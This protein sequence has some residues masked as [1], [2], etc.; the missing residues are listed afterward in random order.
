MT[1]P[2]YAQPLHQQ[3]YQLI[4]ASQLVDAHDLLI[5]ALEQDQSNPETWQL[6]GLIAAVQHD[7]ETAITLL[8]Q[9][10]TL[11]G[12]NVLT[13]KLLGQLALEAG[14]PEAAVSWLT[15][16]RRAAPDD[17]EAR[18]A[19]ACAYAEAGETERAKRL[20]ASSEPGEPAANVDILF[21][22]ALFAEQQ[23]EWAEARQLLAKV[24]EIAPGHAKARSEMVRV[25]N[26]LREHSLAADY[27]RLAVAAEPGDESLRIAL[28]ESLFQIQDY[29]AYRDEILRIATGDWSD[30]DLLVRALYLLGQLHAKE[31]RLAEAEQ[32][33]D[34]AVRLAPLNPEVRIAAANLLLRMGK[35]DLAFAGFVAAHTAAGPDTP[36]GLQA[37]VGIARCAY[38]S[39]APAIANAFLA[40]NLP[41]EPEKRHDTLQALAGALMNE[42][43]LAEAETHLRQII[44]E[45][46]ERQRAHELL[47][48]ALIDQGKD[49]EAYELL[50]EALKRFPRSYYLHFELSV[51]ALRVGEYGV[52]LR[53]ARRAL[54]LGGKAFEARGNLAVLF[55]ESG[56]PARA[57]RLY[58]ALCNEPREDANA[59]QMRLNHSIALMARGQ[60]RAGLQAYAIRHRIFEHYKRYE[61]P[62]AAPEHPSFA[63]QRVLVVAEQGIGDE[64]LFLQFLPDL[65][66]EGAEI[67][68]EC[69]PKLL[70]LFRRSFPQVT[71]L[72][73]RPPVHPGLKA[74]F[75]WQI[76]AGDLM[77]RHY[78]QHDAFRLPRGGFLR[79]D[80]SR[81]GYWK[82]RLAGLRTG[83]RTLNVG[84]AWRSKLQT[85][86]RKQFWPPLDEWLPLMKTGNLNWVV[87][88][89]D[90]NP[91]ELAQL[92]AQ[93]VR[94]HCFA[95]IDQFD[96]V[97]EVAALAR[98]LDLVVSAPVSVPML[99]AAVGTPAW[100]FQPRFEWSLFGTRRLP[101]MPGIRPFIRGYHQSWAEPVEAMRTALERRLSS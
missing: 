55:A 47:A 50:G 31:D 30:T 63:G 59:R 56:Q 46:P 23:R 25:L 29:G 44:A 85:G 22:K 81:V 12:R 14:Q 67:T 3:A 32:H 93:G 49:G 33:F 99:S 91:E 79:P 41:Q 97:D 95:E 28:A 21:N 39:G 88:Q 90:H 27:L 16:A 52:G 26:E 57:L 73:R 98:A 70:P 45:R 69:A 13:L 17:P 60:G 1:T 75:D 101:V 78:L 77:I 82:Q 92:A 42:G 61:N 38:A 72:P 15:R 40:E 11:D 35:A 18:A 43:R 54:R 24:L 89:Y 9:S 68:V 84:I 71:F 20:F 62:I 83:E 66:A 96:D 87:L 53:S 2:L 6:L 64:I 80:P 74:S 100:V 8:E 86:R 37:A 10:A 19:L 36:S 5:G 65:I 7:L 58:E 51:A 34:A 4:S 76:A 94:L 48:Q